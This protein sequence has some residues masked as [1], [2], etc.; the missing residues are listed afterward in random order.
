MVNS[1][2]MPGMPINAINYIIEREPEIDRV[3]MATLF[4]HEAEWYK[5]STH[6]ERGIKDFYVNKV[7]WP[8]KKRF[9][10]YFVNR[11]ANRRKELRKILFKA[12]LSEI[13]DIE[14]VEHHIAHAAAAYYSSPY[15]QD[16]D[17]IILTS[18][19]SGDGIS[20][21]VNRSNHIGFERLSS[22]TRDE[23]PGEIYSLFT[24]ILGFKPWEHE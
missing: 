22:N 6:W 16:D 8:F 7:T 15:T 18:D 24:Y 20:S 1:K 19:G 10:P 2:N 4:I 3:A 14:V 13:P 17:V 23:S 12:G 5:Q 11:L 9:S 21:T